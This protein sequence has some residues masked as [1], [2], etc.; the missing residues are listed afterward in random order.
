MVEQRRKAEG[1][2]AVDLRSG[3]R[4]R[5]KQIDSEFQIVGKRVVLRVFDISQMNQ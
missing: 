3:E 1:R 4:I 2:H 5:F